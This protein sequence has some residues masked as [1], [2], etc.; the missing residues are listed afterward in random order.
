MTIGG[1]MIKFP[2]QLISAALRASM[3]AEISEDASPEEDNLPP[4][5]HVEGHKQAKLPHR[6]LRMTAGLPLD[7]LHLD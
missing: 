6:P 7:S 1:S 5:V 4:L 2:W 3:M